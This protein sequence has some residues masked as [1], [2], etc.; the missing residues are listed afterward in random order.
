M[1]RKPTPTNILDDVLSAQ[2]STVASPVQPDERPLIR[3]QLRYDYSLVPEDQRDQVQDAAVDIVQHGRK[4]QENLI[5]VGKR[6]I[7]VKA[8]L[9]HGQFGDWCQTEFAMSE[10]T[11]QNMMNVA[12]AFDGKSEKIALLGDS[13]LYMLAAPSVPE[14]AR[15]QVIEEATAAGAGPKIERV[16]AVIAQHKPTKAQRAADLVPDV[17]AYLLA[18]RDHLGRTARDL[19][20]K[21]AAH[22]NSV[23]W[24]DITQAWANRSLPEDVLMQAIKGAFE[25]LPSEPALTVP[26]QSDLLA[27]LDSTSQTFDVLSGDESWLA[28]YMSD[29]APAQG[30][31]LP[32]ARA[33]AAIQAWRQREFAAMRDKSTPIARPAPSLSTVDSE[34]TMPADLAALGWQLRQLGDM[35]R[36]YAHNGQQHKATSAVDNWRDAVTAARDMQRNLLPPADAAVVEQAFGPDPLAATLASAPTGWRERSQEQATTMLAQAIVHRW[37]GVD[38]WSLE[39]KDAPGLGYRMSLGAW[40]DGQW[41]WF[42]GATMTEVLT[43]AEARL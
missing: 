5:E 6:L 15:V 12:R 23:L 8:L 29:K 9:D 4:A 19:E 33:L 21:S 11:V 38:R 22:R 20:P 13:T 27:W 18:Y 1:T 14:A 17:V 34:P 35:G 40:V 26:S 30:W 7:Q 16:K 28:Q 41:H 3:S 39:F 43:R 36:W 25:H 42:D 32:E 10:R 37:P 24:R 31:Q 2:P